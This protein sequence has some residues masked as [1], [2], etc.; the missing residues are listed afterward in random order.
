MKRK[1]LHVKKGDRVMLN[2]AITSA[3]S[4]GADQEKGYIGKVLKVFPKQERVI[5]EGVNIRV[6][7]E[8]PSPS[9]Q[10]G[11]RIQ[12]EAPIHVSN[13]N[14]VDSNGE[15]TRIGR[16]KVEDPET[17]RSYWVRVAKTTGEELDT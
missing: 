5:V 11:G 12:R 9:N 17:G 15:P 3:R 16:K 8:Q 14:P 2:K 4:S 10:Q 6:F 7:H 1:K 13:V